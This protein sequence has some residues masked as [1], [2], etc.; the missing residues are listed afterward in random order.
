[1][2]RLIYLVVVIF[3]LSA[4]DKN[5]EGDKNDE[6]GE[7]SGIILYQGARDKAVD[8]ILVTMQRVGDSHVYRSER[9]TNTGEYKIQGLSMGTYELT[10][11][12]WGVDT[13]RQTIRIP[14]DG[15]HDIDMTQVIVRPQIFQNGI[16]VGDIYDMTETP[17]LTFDILNANRVKMNWTVE[18]PNEDWISVRPE[19]G[20]I[21]PGKQ[22]HAFTII[23]DKDKLQSANPA[24]ININS[25]V[26]S[27]SIKISV[28]K[29]LYVTTFS[30]AV[31]SSYSF[32]MK[33]KV[34]F[35]KSI[36][37]PTEVGFYYGKNVNPKETG[38][39]IALDT[40]F[41]YEVYYNG[42]YSFDFSKSLS[43][44]NDFLEDNT[45]YYVQAYARN[46]YESAFGD[47]VSFLC[48]PY[49]K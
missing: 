13:V 1:M 27:S 21:P 46:M 22:D 28:A 18:K 17:S 47:V 41:Y 45:T 29:N 37:R 19:I 26:G 25:N 48:D 2:K 8:G 6:K 36:Y 32:S 31:G 24:V 23:I 12:G 33:G 40:E 15:K 30:V 11:S 3:V 4:C 16:P 34:F 49:G 35:N 38:T 10:A 42:Q 43:Y 7:I 14:M 44:F 39:R 20:E 9:T 5:N